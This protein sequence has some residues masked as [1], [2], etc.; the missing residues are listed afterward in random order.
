MTLRVYVVCVEFRN[1][2]LKLCHFCK[3][4]TGLFTAAFI[5]GVSKKKLYNFE[6]V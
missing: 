3:G 5:Q 6:S 2:F 4:N 1:Q